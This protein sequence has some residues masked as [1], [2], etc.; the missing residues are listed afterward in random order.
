MPSPRCESAAPA[1][2]LTSRPSSVSSV[3]PALP[4][5]TATRALFACFPKPLPSNTHPTKSAS[6]LSTLE[7]S[8]PRCSTSLRQKNCSPSSMPLPSNEAPSPR[9]RMVCC[10]PCQRRSLVRHRLRTCGGRRLYR[11]IE[12][13]RAM[14]AEIYNWFTEGFDTA[15]LKTLLKELDRLLTAKE[16][17]GAI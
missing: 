6:T 8:S 9:G 3:H 10:I 4:P 17:M 14:L 16:N 2:S 7:S 1:P 11:A 15:D 12:E 13:G 5:I